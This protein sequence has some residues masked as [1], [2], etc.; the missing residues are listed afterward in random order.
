MYPMKLCL[1]LIFRQEEYMHE[2]NIF[3]QD[4]ITTPSSS[5]TS[6][7]KSYRRVVND[8]T[9][10]RLINIQ[11]ITL[12]LNHRP[13]R[14]DNKFGNR[15]TCVAKHTKALIT[16]TMMMNDIA[17]AGQVESM[18]TTHDCSAVWCLVDT[19]RPLFEFDLCPV[20]IPWFGYPIVVFHC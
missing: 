2:L 8:Y 11:W 20:P 4:F 14:Y 15:K 7:D 10:G 19:E 6:N 16:P 12:L 9:T 18:K 13:D 3:V 1:S 17:T 5:D